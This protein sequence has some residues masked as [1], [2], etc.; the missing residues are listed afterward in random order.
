MAKVITA[1]GS[2]ELLKN[3]AML[4]RIDRKKMGRN[5]MD[6]KLSADLVKRM[7]ATDPGALRVNKS[8]FT[9]ESTEG[10]MDVYL[11]GS[12]YFYSTT[13]Q[14]ND[15]QARYAGMGRTYGVS[16]EYFWD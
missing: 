7:G 1:T 12:K 15:M 3:K 16:I 5:K 8:I 14:N 13:L 11:E 6:K 10:Y 4:V 2:T 9:K